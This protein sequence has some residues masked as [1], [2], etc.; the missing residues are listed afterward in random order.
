MH[1]LL[2]DIGFNLELPIVNKADNIGSLFMLQNA[3]TR[4]YLRY[5]DT[6]YHF[7]RKNVE[8]GKINFE[9]VKSSDIDYS[10]IYTKNGSF[11]G[12]LEKNMVHPLLFSLYLFRLSLGI[13]DI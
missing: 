12:I 9:F 5:M 13:F 10:D 6:G 3:L 2:Q 4:I 11:Q 7:I 8:D 1:Y